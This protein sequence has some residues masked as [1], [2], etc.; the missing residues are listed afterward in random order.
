MVRIPSD[1]DP[2]AVLGVAPTA[3]PA[4]IAHA[5][6]V[7]LRTLHPDTRHAGTY[8]AGVQTQLQQVLAAYHLLR[9]EPQRSGSNLIGSPSAAATQ[10]PHSTD[11]VP[12]HAT[13]KR[14]PPLTIPIADY[15]T[16]SA[17]RPEGFT[18]WAGPVQWHR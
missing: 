5:F 17:T 3:S 12:V 10:Q 16:C 13:P 4:E 18:L 1:L 14:K 15:R 7:K 2:Y 6:R 8:T 9:S 11:S